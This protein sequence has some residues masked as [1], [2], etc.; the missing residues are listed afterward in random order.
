[1]SMAMASIAFRMCTRGYKFHLQLIYLLISHRFTSIY[2]YNIYIAICRV[3][4]QSSSATPA[5]R[6][7]RL[8]TFEPERY[9]F[10]SSVFTPKCHVGGASW[11][12]KW[13]FIWVK[14]WITYWWISHTWVDFPEYFVNHG[15]TLLVLT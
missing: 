1:M 14:Q 4:L 13:A 15:N 10:A 8:P 3:I 7:R 6:R 9:F 11:D 12:E 5:V 2:I